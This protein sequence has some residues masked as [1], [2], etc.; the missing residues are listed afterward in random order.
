MK[1]QSGNDNDFGGSSDG[2]EGS[3]DLTLPTD[4]YHPGRR[5]CILDRA[6]KWKKS[7]A[8]APGEVE[9]G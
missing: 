7:R 2:R 8:K 3:Y 1:E 5:L 4:P 9:N 6:V